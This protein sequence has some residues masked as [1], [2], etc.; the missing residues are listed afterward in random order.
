MKDLVNTRFPIVT[1]EICRTL[2]GHHPE[3][4]GGILKKA[5]GLCIRRTEFG[6]AKIKT[7]FRQ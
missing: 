7:K 6:G 5:F 3:I 4:F 1:Y 2:L